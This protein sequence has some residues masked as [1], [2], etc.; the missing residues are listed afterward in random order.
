LR[1]TRLDPFAAQRSRREE[2]RLITWYC[3]LLDQALP[4][5]RPANAEVVAQIVRL[6]EQIRG[7]ED[8]KSRNAA[9]AR[10]RAADL[11]GQLSRPPLPLLP[12]RP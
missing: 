10:E 11:L 3:D 5:L 7:Y 8:V 2:R 6:P 12:A 4:A 9:K 1:G